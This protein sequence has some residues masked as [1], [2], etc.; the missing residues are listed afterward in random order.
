VDAS[1]SAKPEEMHLGGYH[2]LVAG[3]TVRALGPMT[4]GEAGPQK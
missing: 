3:G 4:A 1:S 2:L